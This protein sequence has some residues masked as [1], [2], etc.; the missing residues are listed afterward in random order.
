MR[1]HVQVR[2]PLSQ[3]ADTIAK[4]SP[5]AVQACKQL[6]NETWRADPGPG[7]ALE[8]SLQTGLIGTRN[9][10]EAVTASLEKREPIFSDPA[11]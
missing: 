4:R 9:Q 2:R 11:S 5:Q 10:R 3:L 6:Y 1:T 8:A 7:L